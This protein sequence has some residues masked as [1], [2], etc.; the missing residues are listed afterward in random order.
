[1]TTPPVLEG[2][3]DIRDRADLDALVNA[4]Y[5]RVRGDDLLGFIFEEIAQTDW[6][7][8]L[9]RMVMFWERVIFGTGG[10]S[11]SPLAVHAKLAG[12]TEMGVEQF[13]RWVALFRE[14]VRERFAGE[15]A[16]HA[17]RFAED[18]AHVM[19]SRINGVPDPR[20]STAGRTSG[21]GNGP[22]A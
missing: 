10:Y 18:M 6:E 19:Y 2:K 12:R 20:F 3:P 22:A 21:C 9:P 4:F 11:G 16:E 15:R 5:G 8:H 13:G 7:S 17:I 1:M 14:T